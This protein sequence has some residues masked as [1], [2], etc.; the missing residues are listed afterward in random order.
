MISAP[1][2]PGLLASATL[3]AA[4]T[5]WTLWVIVASPRSFSS[6]LSL[7]NRAEDSALRGT[8]SVQEWTADDGGGR[9]WVRAE[10][11]HPPSEGG[12]GGGRVYRWEALGREWVVEVWADASFL[13]PSTLMRHESAH[14]ATVTTPTLHA[15]C[16]HT[17][18]LLG[19][20]DSAVALN[21]CRGLVSRRIP[22]TWSP[23]LPILVSLTSRGCDLHVY[24]PPADS[25]HVCLPMAAE[26]ACVDITAA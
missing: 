15:H 7:V 21:V 12:R 14:E 13:S 1:H 6:H 17:G 5:L 26:T 2:W 3:V 19:Y 22:I 11:A 4:A 9:V 20:N 23:R 10:A 18:V 24:L 8:P 16:F 25:G